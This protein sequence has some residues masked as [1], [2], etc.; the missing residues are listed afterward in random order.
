MIGRILRYAV[1][2]SSFPFPSFV[3][4]SIPPSSRLI[5]HH[6]HHKILRYSNIVKSP[7]SMG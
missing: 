6:H 3:K 2:F 7:A 4:I 1:F 5:H